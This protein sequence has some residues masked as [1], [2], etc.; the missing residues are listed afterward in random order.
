MNNTKQSPSVESSLKLVL[1]TYSNVHRGSGQF[2]LVTTL[3]Y[4]EARRRVLASAGT[5]AH[6]RVVVFCS[7]RRAEQL[8]RH[9]PAGSFQVILPDSARLQM[10]VAAVI[11]DRKIL[12]RGI[13]LQTG[14]GNARLV[15]K[16]DVVWASGPGRHEAGTP[17]ILNTIGLALQLEH[18]R[19]SPAYHSTGPR[20]AFP[21]ANEILFEDPYAGLTGKSLLEALKSAIAGRATRV[22][23]ING[24]Q[25]YVNLDYAASTPAFEPVWEVFGKTIAAS[26]P[27]Q[28][29]II[30]EVRTICAQFVQAPEDKYEIIFTTNTTESINLV[31]ESMAVEAAADHVPVILNSLL[32]HNTNELP[33]RHVPNAALERL[34]VDSAGEIS[35]GGLEAVLRDYNFEHRH[36]NKRIRLISLSGASNVLGTCNDLEAIGRLARQYGTRLLVDAAQLVAH[37]QIEMDRWGIDFLAFSAHKAYAP[38]GTGVLVARRDLL[39][40]SREEKEQIVL[41]G[42]ANAGG[43]AALGKS[44]L[45]LQRIGFDAIRAEEQSLTALALEKMKAVKDLKIFG[46][47][48]GSSPQMLTKTGVIAFYLKDIIAFKVAREL[49][50]RGIGVR[51]G[52]HCAHMLIKHLLQIP[53]FLEKF[54]GVIIRLFPKLSLPGVVRVSMGIGT[55]K[56]DIFALVKALHEIANGKKTDRDM[57]K[58]LKHFT[59]QRLKLVFGSR[60]PDLVN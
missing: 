13:P 27:V 14:G 51:S 9:M 29:E 22:P 47:Q 55:T 43:I 25:P 60:Q 41:S 39:A 48:D 3:L 11:A 7:P 42:E 5:A 18:G 54:Q 49:A 46:L 30:R 1:E 19:T 21:A 36:G 50:Y 35:L 53:P 23:A 17:A 56:E 34:P 15:A 12:P 38:F 52:C 37:R 31:A 58:E 24:M 20:P 26:R 8:T 16:N 6:G 45:L 4:E 59:D 33:W 10:G 57:G 44:L 2:S 40:F 28:Q 32:E